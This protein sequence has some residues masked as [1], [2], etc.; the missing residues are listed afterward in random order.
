MVKKRGIKIKINN[1]RV[2]ALLEIGAEMLEEFKPRNEHQY[3]LRE[4]L[5]E[6]HTGLRDMLKK[7]PGRIFTEAHGH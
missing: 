2:A 6:L 5:L 3:L 1:Q 4:Y 7:K